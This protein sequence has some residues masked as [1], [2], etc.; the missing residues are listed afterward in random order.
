MRKAFLRALVVSAVVQFFITRHLAGEVIE[1]GRAERMWMMY[2]A[3]VVLNALVWAL[4]ARGVTV[5]VR[6]ARRRLIGPN[7]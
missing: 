2:P 4:I 3:N 6:V 1:E 5:F 7:G